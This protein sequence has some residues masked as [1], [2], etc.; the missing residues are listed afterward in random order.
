M[1]AVLAIVF[2][3]SVA[4]SAVLKFREYEEQWQA[5]KSFHDKSYQTD[6][7]EQARYAIWRDNLR[8]CHSR[9]KYYILLKRSSSYCQNHSTN[10]ARFIGGA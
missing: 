3:L 5:W 1:K 2:C 10:L 9:M 4:N 8:V 7:E 6:T